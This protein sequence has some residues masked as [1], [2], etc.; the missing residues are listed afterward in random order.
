M[1]VPTWRA[2]DVT[3]EIDVVEEVARVV[4]DRVPTT[5]PLRRV[6]RGPPVARAAASAARSR[7]CSSARG[8][9]E[10]Y[11]WSLVAVRSRPGRAPAPRP[12]ERRARG[13]AHDAA[14]RPRRGGARQRRRRQH[15]HPA[16]RDRAGLP[17]VRRAAAGRAVAR[18]RDRGGRLRGRAR[19]GR[20]DLRGV[21]PAARGCA[22]R[23]S[24]HL[25]PGKA[26]ETDAGWL[27]EL[28]PTLLEGAWGVFELD[29]A[30]AD[31]AAAGADPLRGRDH[32]SRR[33]AGRRRR[34]RRGRRGRAR[35]SPSRARRAAPS[36]ARRA[37]ST[38]TTATRWGRG[39]SPSPCTSSSRRPTGR[40]RTRRRTRRERGSS[41]RCGD[42]FGAEL[43]A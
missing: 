20:G 35:S 3:R 26:A 37:S 14:P 32:V 8:S 2:R 15:G 34:R 42:R 21:P 6:G 16:V 19:G 4:L 11:T 25:H 23:R 9:R 27:G 17:P 1:T 36:S 28:H 5:M 24:P 12:D 40:S 39:G 7:T 29:V 18:R 31:G 33:P 41:T 38:S 13:A 10:A 30:R 22:A 43:R